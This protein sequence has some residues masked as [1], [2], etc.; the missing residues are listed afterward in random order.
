[1][2]NKTIFEHF[3]KRLF[4]WISLWKFPY[5]SRL[6]NHTIGIERK[7]K[8]NLFLG[9]IGTNCSNWESLNCKSLTLYY[10]VTTA[11]NCP[12]QWI[13]Q[14]LETA[15]IQN[16]FCLWQ[17]LYSLSCNCSKV[18]YSWQQFE[19]ETVQNYLFLQLLEFFFYVYDNS[20]KLL[21]R[22]ISYLT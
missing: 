12:Q 17:Q 7:I 18:S 19:N 11:Q 10:Y 15:T 14:L 1:M 2:K 8:I 5:I 4:H 16:Y 21:F 20:L 13:W 3:Y 22:S 6:H 9:C